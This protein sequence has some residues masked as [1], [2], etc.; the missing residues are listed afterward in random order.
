MAEAARLSEDKGAAIIDINL[1]CPVRKVTSGDA[2]SALMRDLGLAARLIDL[3][4]GPATADRGPPPGRLALLPAW[5]HLAA[6]LGLGLLMPAGVV[7]WLSSIA[8]T[9][10]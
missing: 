1:G 8:V 2:G 6:A 3:C 4:L 7:S 9:V 10:R 5:L